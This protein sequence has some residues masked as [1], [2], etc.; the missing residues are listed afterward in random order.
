MKQPRTFYLA[1]SSS[2]LRAA[3]SHAAELVA[4]GLTWSYDW[5]AHFRDGEQFPADGAERDLRG[6]VSAD[7]FVLLAHPPTQGGMLELGAR[8]EH[9][10]SRN[11]PLDCPRSTHVVLSPV[12]DEDSDVVDDRLH[13]FHYHPGVTCVHRCWADFL[14]WIARRQEN[15]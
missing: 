2:D 11:K 15:L 5:I 3:A 9:D 12:A 10:R 14:N 6:A 4:M 8:L 7:V 13:F 1:A